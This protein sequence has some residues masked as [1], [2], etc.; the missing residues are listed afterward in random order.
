MP[1]DLYDDALV[2]FGYG[3]GAGGYP[4]TAN[5]DVNP[6]ALDRVRDD[7]PIPV[8]V[9]EWTDADNW[10]YLV[11]PRLFPVIQMSYAQLPGGGRHPAPEL[12]SVSNPASGLMFTND[13]MPVKVRDWFAYGV[14]GYR[15]VGKR[16]VG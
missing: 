6:Y 7:R 12:F 1:I 9:P 13:V 3:Q 15:G 4:G 11:D 8:K 10:A 16:N 2:I 5:N 14:S